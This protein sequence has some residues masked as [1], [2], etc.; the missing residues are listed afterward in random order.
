MRALARGAV[1]AVGR[2]TGSVAHEMMEGQYRE[3]L[4]AK[5]D[6]RRLR[7][8]HQMLVPVLGMARLFEHI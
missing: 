1:L 2:A 4:L 5:H 8:F 7:Q 6:N 3:G